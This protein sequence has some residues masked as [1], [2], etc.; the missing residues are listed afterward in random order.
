[1]LKHIET[2]ASYLRA[3]V[4]IADEPN[5]TVPDNINE[6]AMLRGLKDMFA[7]YI[8]RMGE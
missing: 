1:M 3:E 6:E 4:E 5:F 8:S 7:E 2:E